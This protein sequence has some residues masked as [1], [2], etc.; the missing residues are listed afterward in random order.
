MKLPRI[1]LKSLLTLPILPAS[2]TIA[3]LV[4]LA[5]AHLVA[6]WLA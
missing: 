6:R 3:V 4:A 1:P 5:V 2:G